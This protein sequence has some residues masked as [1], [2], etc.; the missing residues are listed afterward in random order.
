[1]DLWAWESNTFV[2]L[3]Q[4]EQMNI[5]EC[6]AGQ[7]YSFERINSVAGNLSDGCFLV[8]ANMVKETGQSLSGF[9]EALL[10]PLQPAEPDVN[11]VETAEQK[12]RRLQMQQKRGLEQ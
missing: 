7:H 9:I 10:E 5:L 2:S 3:F 8:V 6:S 4:K 12:R 11:L 1:M